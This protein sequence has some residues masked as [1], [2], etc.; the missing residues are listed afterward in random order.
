VWFLLYAVAKLDL[1]VPATLLPKL[2][3]HS[4]TLL[5]SFTPIQL[6]N[7]SWAVA[8]LLVRMRQEG[9]HSGGGKGGRGATFQHRNHGMDWCGLLH[10]KS[11]EQSN[12]ELL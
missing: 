8:R 12:V 10:Q 2:L 1:E 11:L 5:T 9:V 4:K 7:T 6:A 3:Y